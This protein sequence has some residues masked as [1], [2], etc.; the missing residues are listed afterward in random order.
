M[1]VP[2][3]GLPRPTPSPPEQ[4]EELQQASELA[5]RPEVQAKLAR[6]IASCAVK[7]LNAPRPGKKLLVADIDVSACLLRLSSLRTPS[8]AACGE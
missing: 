7:T 4:E 8:V 6:R 1:Y 3:P 5:E 2:P